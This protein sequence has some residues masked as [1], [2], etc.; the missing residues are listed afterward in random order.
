MSDLSQPLFSLSGDKDLHK[1]QHLQRAWLQMMIKDGHF[2]Y[3]KE[4]DIRS[5]LKIIHP[6]MVGS[7]NREKVIEC[8]CLKKPYQL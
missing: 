4:G 1:E 6:E 7:Y 5:G 2:E 8:L 3:I